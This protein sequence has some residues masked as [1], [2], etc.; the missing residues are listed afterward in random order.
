MHFDSLPCFSEQQWVS[1]FRAEGGG[2]TLM[3]LGRCEGSR[4]S[5]NVL[6]V[7]L[8]PP[9]FPPVLRVPCTCGGRD[10]VAGLPLAFQL[11]PPTSGRTGSCKEGL[12]RWDFPWLIWWVPM[13]WVKRFQEVQ[14]ALQIYFSFSPRAFPQFRPPLI[15]KLGQWEKKKKQLC[16]VLS[17][18]PGRVPPDQALSAFGTF[19]PRCFTLH[20]QVDLDVL[21]PSVRNL[22]QTA[23]LKN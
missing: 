11:R 5:G 8:S 13:S 9:A 17:L 22:L 20:S 16:P 3:L 21:F 4:G 7:L 1:S 18:L 12:S 19:L 6:P 23:D 2:L 14:M 15:W 10:P